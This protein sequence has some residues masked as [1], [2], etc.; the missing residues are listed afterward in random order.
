MSPANTRYLVLT[1]IGHN[2]T[3]LVSEL[4]GLVSRCNCNVV[5]SKM[6][7]FG[8]EFTVIMLVSGDNACLVQLE[9]QLPPLAMELHLLTMMKRTNRHLG[10]NKPQYL[11]S[12]EGPD[13]AGT[14]KQITSY[15][16]KQDIDVTSLRSNT[17][18]KYNQEWQDAEIQIEL[19]D[20]LPIEH[21][22]E[23]IS[24]ECKTLNMEFSLKPITIEE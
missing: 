24:A 5:D 21:L 11:L 17:S 3:G 20:V 15:L 9:V 18:T 8:G 2:K 19:P 1:A 7:I 14:I 23:D 12:I 6:A 16:A 10:I 22:S 4:T 13:Q